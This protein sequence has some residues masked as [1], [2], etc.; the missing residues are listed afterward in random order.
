MLGEPRNLRDIISFD[1]FDYDNYREGEK[2]IL[3]PQIEALGYTDFYWYEQE[4]VWQRDPVRMCRALG[5]KTHSLI[6]GEGKKF[7]FYYG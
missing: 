3:Q 6:A 7:Y 5:G 1:G 2:T 4:V